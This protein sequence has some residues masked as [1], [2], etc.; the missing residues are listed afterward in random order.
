VGAAEHSNPNDRD[1]NPAHQT[2][3]TALG[4]QK[5]GDRCDAEGG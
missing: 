5:P 2:D 1:S 4:E 3:P